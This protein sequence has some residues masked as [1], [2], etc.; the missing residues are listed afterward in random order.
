MQLVEGE[1]SRRL[2]V[3]ALPSLLKSLNQ[4]TTAKMHPE[5]LIIQRLDDPRLLEHSLLYI[6]FEDRKDWTLSVSEEAA[7]RQIDRLQKVRAERDAS[8]VDGA[9][10]A[11]E[12]GARS[13]ANLL[14]LLLDAVQAY[15]S[16]GQLCD[17]LR[18]VFGEYEESTM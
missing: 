2:Y 8:V 14:P 12:A 7:R 10:L 18:R 15:A 16:V 11:L 17:A 4:E 1:R 13:E 5:P 9:L 3:D 6:N